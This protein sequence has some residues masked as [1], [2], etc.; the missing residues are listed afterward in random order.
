MQ[1]EVFR[2]QTVKWSL[3][4]RAEALADTMAGMRRFVVFR[5]GDLSETHNE[6]QVNAADEPQYEGVVFTDG[7]CVL[8]WR[9]A[10][11]STSVWA[12]F[13]EMWKIHGHDDPNSKHGTELVW[14]DET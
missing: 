7:T 1:S 11:K 10:G 4:K 9:T 12:S 2:G 5:R 3:Q 6:D 13:D 8:R 14:M